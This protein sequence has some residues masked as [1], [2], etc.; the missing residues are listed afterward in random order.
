MLYGRIKRSAGDRALQAEMMERRIRPVKEGCQRLAVTLPPVG[1]FSQS[2]VGGALWHVCD[3]WHEP[4]NPSL[5]PLLVDDRRRSR[6]AD[7]GSSALSDATSAVPKHRPRVG[8]VSYLNSKPL[9][10]GL[11]GRLPGPLLLDY[12]S[13]LASALES[14]RLDVALVPSI[15]VLR[16]QEDYEIVSDA[17]VAAQGPVRSVKV[18]FRKHPGEVR[19]LALD[20][21]SRTSA[22]L[23]RVLLHHKYGVEPQ[24]E[25]LPLDIEPPR[26][27]DNGARLGPSTAIG[28]TRADAILV[29][30]DRAMFPVAEP[31]ETVWDLGEEWM[32]WTG[33]PFVFAV[34][35]GRRGEVPT[36]LAELFSATRD[37]GVAAAEAIARRE[38]VPLGID[39]AVAIDYLTKNLHF[40][41]GPAERSGLK[42]FAQLAHQAGLAPGGIDLVFRDRSDDFARQPTTRQTM[43]PTAGPPRH[44]LATR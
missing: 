19:T 21:G 8:A 38:A 12:P 4:Y 16:A 24:V 3:G 40:T 30:G 34:W 11:A 43:G 1:Y 28:Q 25:P 7:R 20:E 39:P 23:A 15:E 10:D 42:L 29:I 14:A 36:G 5:F 31:F 44:L 41:L 26:G 9:I 17:C 27:H 33:L 13:R 37:A 32:R 2:A 35:A 22:T 6:P 18:Y